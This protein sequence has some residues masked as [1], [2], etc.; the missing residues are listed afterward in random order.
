MRPKRPAKKH[1]HNLHE[2]IGTLYVSQLKRART[3]GILD[4]V[5]IRLAA[6]RYY[7]VPSEKALLLT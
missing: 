7:I 6:A 4:N 5:A 3:N 1:K 2:Q